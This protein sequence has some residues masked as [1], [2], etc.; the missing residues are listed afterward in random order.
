MK[1]NKT[2]GE[3]VK[4]EFENI[5]KQGCKDMAEKIFGYLTEALQYNRKHGSNFIVLHPADIKEIARQC[6]IEIKE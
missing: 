1:N 6:S 3:V 4:K 2:L 5:Y